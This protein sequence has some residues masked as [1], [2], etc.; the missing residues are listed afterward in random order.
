ML[1]TLTCVHGFL[2]IC[3]GFQV[4]VPAGQHHAGLNISREALVHMRHLQR[5]VSAACSPR[6][7]L[8]HLLPWLLCLPQ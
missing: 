1:G 4:L 8:E 5:R 2:S 6:L 7:P 3:A